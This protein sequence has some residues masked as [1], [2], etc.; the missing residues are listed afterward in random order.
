M[1]WDAFLKEVVEARCKALEV[2]GDGV[3][4]A[5][6]VEV[7]GIVKSRALKVG[8]LDGIIVKVAKK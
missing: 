3:V 4:E 7:N 2:S 6:T 1:F 5:V 8:E